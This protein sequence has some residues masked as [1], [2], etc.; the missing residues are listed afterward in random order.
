MRLT[1]RAKLF[2]IAGMAAL[3]FFLLIV[4]SELLSKRVEQRL[5][6]I[7]QLYLPKMEA[8][9]LL[10]GQLERLRRGFQDAV[11]S[12]DRD[13]LATTAALKRTFLEELTASRDALDPTEVEE[14][15]G[16]LE[17]YYVAA[18][19]V[20]GR[21]IANETGEPVLGAIEDMQGKQARVGEILARTT[22]FDRRQ[23]ADAFRAAI[24]D[25]AAARAYRLWIS[26]ACLFLVTLASMRV[27]RR[28]VRSLGD[29]AAGFERFGTGNF[30]EPIHVTSRDEIEDVARRANDMAASLARFAG[31]LRKAEEKFRSLLEA[32]PDAMI[33]V[34]ANGSIVLVNVQ[35]EKLFGYPRNELLGQSV[36]MLLPERQRHR[37][38]GHRAEY[39]SGPEARSMGP[40]LDLYGLRKDGTEFPIETRL[41]PIATED[42]ILVSSATRDITDRKR[43][44]TALRRANRELEA[45]SYSVA[46]DLRAPLRGMNGFAQILLDD[47]RDRLDTDAIDCIHK[48][49]E[50]TVRMGALIDALLSLARMTR[51]ELRPVWTDLSALVR[52]VVARL[53]AT[54]PERTV[55][56]TVGDGLQARV[57]PALGRNLIENLMGNAWKYTSKSPEARIEFGAIEQDG[58]RVFFV[59]DNGAGFNMDHA[60][61]LF[62]PFQRLHSA[63]EF[64]GTGIGLATS[65]RI[66][67]SHGGRIWAEGDVNRGATFYFSLPGQPTERT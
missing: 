36:E 60:G 27:A 38:V 67:D 52:S 11:A 14:L 19:D 34:D 25:V 46:H 33:I 32:A 49:M 41:G 22:V 18:V 61:K 5:F 28:L 45:F 8:G 54:H 21:L 47:Y 17:D 48:I 40:E 37:H 62:V 1:F 56:V 30:A 4:A 44:E 3:A 9:P 26:L 2:A 13:A 63:R 7:R 23:L 15:R 6:T 55:Q 64:P 43:V 16:A 24:D 29:L 35:A 42:G 53:A 51:S 58:S 59:R 20:S 31:E 10:D 66:V 57:D 39:L 50:N 12:R 65:H